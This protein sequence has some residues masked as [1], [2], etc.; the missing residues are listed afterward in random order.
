MT[1][2]GIRVRIRLLSPIFFLLMIAFSGARAV[3]PPLTA[4]AVHEFSHLICAVCLKT[5]IDEIELMPFGAAIR[6][7]ALWEI[8]PARLMAIALAG[9]IANLLITSLLSL[10]IFFCPHLSSAL[11]P[12]LFSNLAIA[13][14][15]LLPALP[16]DGG[17][18]LC[19]LLAL[20]IKRSRSIGIGI[21]LG[22]V[23]GVILILSSIYT[24]IEAHSFP[25]QPF[26][27]SVYLFASGEQEK[28]NSEGAWIRSIML[29]PISVQPVRRPGVLMVQRNTPLLECVGAVRPG[30]DALFAVL[31]EEKKILAFLSL[32]QVV[33]A[34]KEKSA[35]SISDVLQ[36]PACKIF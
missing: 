29:N 35:G 30:E 6:L 15:N 20:K 18:F 21:L 13:L 1:L 16:L 8:A 36:N 4:L 33:F 25:L 12:F 11:S 3:F 22:R 27:A 5:H 14:I 23:L 17:R 34:L 19:A 7:Y 10:L 32:S 31:S 26:L 9:P 28:R 2:F 24:C